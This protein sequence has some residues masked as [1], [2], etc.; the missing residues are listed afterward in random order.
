MSE[1]TR[2]PRF[3]PSTRSVLF[4]AVPGAQLLDIVG[5]MEC[6]DAANKLREY[7]GKRACYTFDV[8]A[9]TATVASA[10]GLR[11]RTTPLRRARP[12]HT[13]VIGGSLGMVRRNAVPK[14]T[15]AQIAR[16]AKGSQRVVSVCAGSFVLDT[17]RSPVT[18]N[19]H[20]DDTGVCVQATM[21]GTLTSVRAVTSPVNAANLPLVVSER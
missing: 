17:A 21:T 12:P 11:V 18:V 8:A 2:T 16:L 9:S 7:E 15:L 1:M 14:A 3:L 6:F 20:V 10:A 19:S 13:L 4:V 5:P